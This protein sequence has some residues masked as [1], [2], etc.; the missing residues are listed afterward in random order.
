[1][2]SFFETWLAAG[3]SQ[4]VNTHTKPLLR[5]KTLKEDPH[6]FLSPSFQINLLYL[7]EQII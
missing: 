3:T 4:N 5:I 7:H 6:S 1:M 2:R